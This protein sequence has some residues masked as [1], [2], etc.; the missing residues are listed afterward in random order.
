MSCRFLV[1]R[2]AMFLHLSAYLPKTLQSPR[3][4]YN[5]KR[6]PD[7]WARENMYALALRMLAP[8]KDI[9]LALQARNRQTV[10]KRESL[11]I[12]SGLFFNSNW[13]GGGWGIHNSWSGT[14]VKQ[15]C[16]KNSRARA[17][18]V[19]L[20]QLQQVSPPPPPHTCKKDASKICH[21]MGVRMA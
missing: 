17:R 15:P 18:S 10:S 12:V 4:P 2:I 21:T 14:C 19:G 7:W 5:K 9:S 16:H 6:D 1:P 13:F 8:L 20:T 3:N 11:N